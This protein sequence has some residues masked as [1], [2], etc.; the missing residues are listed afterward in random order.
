MKLHPA[1]ICALLAM[2]VLASCKNDNSN[3]S[4]FETSYRVWTQF[5]SASKNSY[6]YSVETGS[7]FG[8]STQTIFTIKDGKVVSRYFKAISYGAGSPPAIVVREEWKENEST[9]NTHQYATPIRTL[10]QVY[11][12]AKSNWLNK[13]GNVK[14]YFETK[15]EG[16]ISL[17]G[18]VEDGCQDDCFNGI[19]IGYI[20]KT[21][22]P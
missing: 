11:A 10:D 3:N 18:Y 8:G 2:F 6:E 19:T 4:N 15:N 13:R 5:R 17:C 1:L 16:M 7:V 12:E 21:T 20:K 14:I 22:T 9:L